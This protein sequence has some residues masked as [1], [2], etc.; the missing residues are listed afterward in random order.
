MKPNPMGTKLKPQPKCQINNICSTHVPNPKGK[1]VTLISSIP[2][3]ALKYFAPTIFVK[4][5]HPSL[6]DGTTFGQENNVTN[7]NKQ[8]KILVHTR[9]N[10]IL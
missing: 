10:N 5:N 1:T 7:N 2:K 3:I 9:N 6:P 4:I 8:N